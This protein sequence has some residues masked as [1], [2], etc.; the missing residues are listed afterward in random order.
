MS[1]SPSLASQIGKASVVIIIWS[2]VDKILAIGKEMMTAHRF[3]VSASLD[4]FNLAYSFPGT[5]VLFS[6]VFGGACVPLYLEWRNHS[7]Q[8][9]DSHA[10]WLIYLNALLFA[11]LALICFVF[12]PE[13]IQLIGYGFQP[14][15]KQ[16]AV[17]MEGLLLL[18]I[19]IDGTGILFRGIL[20][21]R[22][23]FSHLYIA[24][25]FVNITLILLLY[26]D[27]GLD[28][29][30][31]VW[32]FLIGT[33]MKTIYMGI[34]LYQT[35][36]QYGTL[37]PFDRQKTKTFFLLAIPMLGTSLIANSNIIID[38][39]MATQLPSGSVSTLRYAFRINDFPVQ[40]VITAISMAIFP[41]ISEEAAAGNQ[42]N[43]KRVF[44]YALIFLG[45]LTIPITCIVVL[46]S[47]DLVILLLKR[48]AFDMEASKQTAQTLVCYSLGLFFYAYTFVNGSFFTALQNTKALLYMT[49]A[50]I[51]LNVFFNF[52]FM[53]LIGVRGIAL[54]T[55]FTMFIL[56]I[57][58][59]Y[60]LKR[61]LGISDLSEIFSSFYRIIIA[62]ACMLGTGFLLLGLFQMVKIEKWIYLPITLT[63][64]CMSYLGVVWMFRTED[65]NA[66]WNALARLLRALVIGK[67]D[68][69]AR[70]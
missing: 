61:R 51:F 58:F 64:V 48:G 69:R 18:L 68:D 23:L 29:Y 26:F 70:I 27:I 31:L 45:F 2:M 38:Q 35:G 40:V 8:E 13:I 17:I 3:G 41:F 67:K 54:S 56:S 42:E 39:V 16:L 57:Y 19:F 11:S 22:K 63:L 37:Q 33:L 20:H 49:I 14:K 47:E 30:V 28:I 36:F 43:L 24:P 55:S 50:S 7:P 66:C 9:A 65:L 59:V 53:H 46:F 52:V 60:L 10:T 21:A 32:G 5:I 44:K 4:A 12:T 34:A 6:S 62:A 25:L 15:E 1:E